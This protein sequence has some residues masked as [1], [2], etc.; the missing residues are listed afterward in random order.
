MTK[1]ERVVCNEYCLSLSQAQRWY[2]GP[3][4][5]HLQQYQKSSDT[6]K[7]TL[8]SCF[9]FFS[10]WSNLLEFRFF[11]I[12]VFSVQLYLCSPCSY[13]K[14]RHRRDFCFDFSSLI[15]LLV[16]FVFYFPKSI[17]NL[18]YLLLTNLSYLLL[19]KHTATLATCFQFQNSNKTNI[20]INSLKRKEKL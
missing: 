1:R 9:F 18:S 5:R 17:S 4:S 15:I 11:S 12:P 20:K 3:E 7:E 14:H 19:T 13:K 16:C 6:F 2:P 8:N 10:P